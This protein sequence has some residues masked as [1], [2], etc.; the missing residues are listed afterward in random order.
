MDKT[1]L[2]VSVV[3]PS[4][5]NYR[6]TMDK[7]ELEQLAASIAE[8]GILQPILVRPVNGH[9]EIV[10]G[11]RRF[12]AAR[13]SGLKEVPVVIRELTDQEALEIQII[14]NSQREDPNPVDE[15]QGFKFLLKAKYDIETIA[16]KIGRKP[17][18]VHGRLRLLDLPKEAQQRLVKGEISFDQAKLLLRLNGKE[19]KGF[20]RE[21]L[22]RSESLAQSKERIKE[23]LDPP[24]ESAL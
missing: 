13:Q 12:A 15:A 14:E 8:K 17:G 10:A 23:I 9:Y 19:Q 16:F 24:E 4:P 6:K 22:E 11:H 21:M 20:L 7:G 1:K 18:Y 5:H 2:A 3:K